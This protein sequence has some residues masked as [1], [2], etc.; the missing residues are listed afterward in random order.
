MRKK[1]EM[2]SNETSYAYV[3]KLIKERKKEKKGRE[4]LTMLDLVLSSVKLRCLLRRTSPAAMV[5]GWEVTPS[6]SLVFFLISS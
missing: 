1:E 3:E 2:G 4:V 5:I 6:Y